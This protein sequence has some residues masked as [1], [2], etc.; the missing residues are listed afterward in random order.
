MLV[1]WNKVKLRYFTG[2][3]GV[4]GVI[5]CYVKIIDRWENFVVELNKTTSMKKY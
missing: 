4:F 5:T 1:K 3:D 2:G